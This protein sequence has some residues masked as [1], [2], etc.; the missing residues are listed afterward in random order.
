MIETT[1]QKNII[2][3]SATFFKTFE[4]FSVREMG[5]VKKIIK[6]CMEDFDE[7]RLANDREI[8]LIIF[9]RKGKQRQL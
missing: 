2:E 3:N 8:S 6:F 4:K 1:I 9:V 5:N 7:F